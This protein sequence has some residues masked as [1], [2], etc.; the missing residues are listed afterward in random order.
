MN[1]REFLKRAGAGTL[2]TVTGLSITLTR[3]NDASK[4][5][6][7]LKKFGINRDPR[8]LEYGHKLPV[9]VY[10]SAGIHEFVLI[11]DVVHQIGSMISWIPRHGLRIEAD[12]ALYLEKITAIVSVSITEG[13]VVD[14]E[15]DCGIEHISPVLRSVGK[16]GTIGIVWNERDGI[17][18]LS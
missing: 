18:S 8:I 16:G 13:I 2:M 10:T 5:E 3:A 14:K 1:R 15:V 9:R 6:N 12:K 17:C 4:F 7:F 11:C